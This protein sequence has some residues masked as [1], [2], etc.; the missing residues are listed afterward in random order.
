MAGH[1]REPWCERPTGLVAPVRLDPAGVNG[2]TRG[3]AQ[4]PRWRQCAH[5]WYVPSDV[6]QDV[7]E[8]RILEQSARLPRGGG[9]T[10]CARLFEHRNFQSSVSAPKCVYLRDTVLPENVNSEMSRNFRKIGHSRYLNEEI[11]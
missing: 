8:Q 6:D 7:V 5:G 10:G 9:I 1:R 2:P 4:G 11:S 3:E